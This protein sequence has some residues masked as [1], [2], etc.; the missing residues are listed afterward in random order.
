MNQKYFV[1]KNTIIQPEVII[2]EGSKIWHFCNLYG[3]RIG[4]N[5]Q[6]GSYSEIKEGAQIGNDCRFQ[7]YVFVPE[8]T[9]I[10][11]SVFVGPRV[12]FLNDKYPNTKKAQNKTWNLESV[13]VEDNATIGG[14]CTIL[15][16]IRICKNAFIGA[17]SVVTRN[18]LKGE[19]VYGN[20]AKVM[21]HIQDKK[22]RGLI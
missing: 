8:G 9:V 16:G 13:I 17:G 12:T 11:N 3:C 22:Y 2:G 4:K 18:V 1:G 7:S 10:G 21:G 5:T 6:I 14:N 20:P 15:P 19:I